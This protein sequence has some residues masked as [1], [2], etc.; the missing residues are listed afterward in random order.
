MRAFLVS[1]I[2]G[3]VMAF[4]AQAY[5]PFEAA[6]AQD[7]AKFCRGYNG[8]EGIRCLIANEFYLSAVCVEALEE[9]NYMGGH[10]SPERRARYFKL[11]QAIRSGQIR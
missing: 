8:D 5:Y 4:S 10:W 11:K 1:L 3:L 9:F 7:K 6:C 2:C